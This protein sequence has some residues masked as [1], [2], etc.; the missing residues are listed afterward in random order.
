MTVDDDDDGCSGGHD[1]D[2][3]ELIKIFLEMIIEM[4][5]YLFV[6]WL[7]LRKFDGILYFLFIII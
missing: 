2:G 5:I 1:G 3:D 4:F 6:V 7:I